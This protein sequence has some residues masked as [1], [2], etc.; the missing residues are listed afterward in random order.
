MKQQLDTLRLSLSQEEGVINANRH[1]RHSLLLKNQR[2]PEALLE[3][4]SAEE[5]LEISDSMKE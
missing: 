1:G 4:K 5:V 3:A 2:K